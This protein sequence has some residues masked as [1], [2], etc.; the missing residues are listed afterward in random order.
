MD[1]GTYLYIV[2]KQLL[3]EHF[4]ESVAYMREL[5]FFRQIIVQVVK[6][7]KIQNRKAS[8]CLNF[9]HLNIN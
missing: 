4:N 7:N 1:L 8:F 5:S 3:Y 2:K 6:V 9:C